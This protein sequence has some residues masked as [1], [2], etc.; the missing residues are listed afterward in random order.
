[1][2]DTNQRL[3]VTERDDGL[4]DFLVAQLLADQYE[5]FGAYTA[6]ETR[7]K[8]AAFGPELV[9]LGELD[10]ERAQLGLLRALRQGSD[11]ALPVVVLSAER[12][13][14]C[15]LRALEAGADDYLRK[16]LA[17]P[18]LRARV[19]ALLRRVY[20]TPARRRIG[21]LELDPLGR[22]ARVAGRPLC[23]SRLEFELLCALAREPRRVYTKAELLRG[24]WGY[25]TLGNTRTLDAHASRLRRK[26]ADAGA[27]G[28]IATVRGVGYRLTLGPVAA[29]PEAE[30]RALPVGVSGRAA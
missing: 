26:L 16:P 28:L 6:E 4:R 22:E 14:L 25:R 8:L 24:V 10:G 18:L 1:M 19:R 13:Q 2:T 12:S 20:G 15:E 7:V 17:Y 3:L 21:A 30:P 29:E 27:P 9:M 23:L 5:A 11:G